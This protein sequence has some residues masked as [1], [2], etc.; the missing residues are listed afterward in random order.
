MPILGMGVSYVRNLMQT[1]SFGIDLPLICRLR[2]PVKRNTVVRC[3]RKIEKL[4]P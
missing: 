3:E 2:H 4:L 1:S